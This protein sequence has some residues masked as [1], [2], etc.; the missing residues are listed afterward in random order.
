MFYLSTATSDY[1]LVPYNRISES[2]KAL[3]S[4]SLFY[5]KSFAL[6]EELDPAYVQ[7]FLARLEGLNQKFIGSAAREVHFKKEEYSLECTLLPDK[8]VLQR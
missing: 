4:H 8:L 5:D 7:S 2:I 3:R 1:I 6:T